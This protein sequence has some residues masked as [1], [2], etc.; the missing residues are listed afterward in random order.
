MNPQVE[1]IMRPWWHYRA[2][3]LCDEFAAAK[4]ER[5]KIDLEICRADLA[6]WLSRELE[7]D[8][9]DLTTL[10]SVDLQKIVNRIHKARK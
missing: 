5:A 9:T 2:A 6:A 1:D 10:N 3:T 7:F 8:C 4:S